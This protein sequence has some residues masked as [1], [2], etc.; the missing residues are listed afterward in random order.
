MEQNYNYIQKGNKD[1]CLN[2]IDKKKDPQ[3][4]PYI[5]GEI[6]LLDTKSKILEVANV[7]KYTSDALASDEICKKIFTEILLEELATL[8]GIP[9]IDTKVVLF[10]AKLNM[11]LSLFSLSILSLEEKLFSLFEF[12]PLFLLKKFKFFSFFFKSNFVFVPNESSFLFTDLSFRQIL[13]SNI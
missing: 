4:P 3:A 1:W 5:C 6:T 11:V 13:L 7:D 2:P 9:V 10:D 8:V 12:I